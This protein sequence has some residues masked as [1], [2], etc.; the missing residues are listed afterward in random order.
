M[1]LVIALV[2]LML[3]VPALLVVSAIADNREDS[4][5]GVHR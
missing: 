2:A 4:R 5:H 1:T 3:A